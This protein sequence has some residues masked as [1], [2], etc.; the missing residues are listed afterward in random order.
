MV[1]K[2]SNVNTCTG[3]NWL[4][5]GPTKSFVNT[6]TIL[7]ISGRFKFV[8]KVNTYD[9]SANKDAYFK[10]ILSAS[11]NGDWCDAWHNWPT[12]TL[13]VHWTEAPDCHSLYSIQ[14]SFALHLISANRQSV[15]ALA[16]TLCSEAGGRD[17]FLRHNQ[18][19]RS[20]PSRLKWTGS[21]IYFNVKTTEKPPVR[22]DIWCRVSYVADARAMNARQFLLS[23][24]ST[25]RNKIMYVACFLCKYLVCGNNRSYSYRKT[26]SLTKVY[27]PDEKRSAGS[28]D[29]QYLTANENFTTH[30]NFTH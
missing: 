13:F 12:Q 11:I 20:I 17:Q 28:S 21:G 9:L 2:G 3:R 18:A 24:V 26:P 15:S 6:L 16:G 23:Y 8:N 14:S 25:Y 1:I 7:R 29:L 22:S 19:N 30:K 5:K 27:E 10:A 4:K